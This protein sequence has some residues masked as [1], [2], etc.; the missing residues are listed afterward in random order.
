MIKSF[1][2]Y[3][4]GENMEE[5]G[6]IK[7]RLSTVILLIVIFLLII[8]MI[9]MYFYFKNSNSS[10][11]LENGQTQNNAS[12]SSNTFSGNSLNNTQSFRFL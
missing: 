3:V 2:K 6:P 9:F 12:V 10:E 1:Y 11:N 7:V 5:K 8:A 4:G